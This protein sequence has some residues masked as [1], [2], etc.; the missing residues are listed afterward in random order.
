MP[1]TCRCSLNLTY[2]FSRA[3]KERLKRQ[4]STPYSYFTSSSSYYPHTFVSASYSDL[5]K[6]RPPKT[7]K[8]TSQQ[9]REMRNWRAVHGQSVPQKTVR[10]MTTKDNPGTLPIN[11]YAVGP[12]D[13]Q[14]LDLT[15][16]GDHHS[17]QQMPQKEVTEFLYTSNQIIRKSMTKGAL[18]TPWFSPAYRRML[19]LALKK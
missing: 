4:C 18:K 6:L 15:K 19:K 1:V 5:P 11:L 2:R 7:N 14:P 3:I 9:V 10:N 17:V 12:P 16:L 13:V 8:L